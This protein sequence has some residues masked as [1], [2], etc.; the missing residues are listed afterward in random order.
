MSIIQ[1]PEPLLIIHHLSFQVK[2]WFQN[3][4]YKLKKSRSSD[5]QHGYSVNPSLPN[6]IAMRGATDS[7][8]K[9]MMHA[10]AFSYPLQP[11]PP[12]NNQPGNSGECSPTGTTTPGIANSANQP[13][14]A[15][16]DYSLQY[17]NYFPSSYPAPYQT[18]Q[19]TP[20]T[21]SPPTASYHHQQPLPAAVP[22]NLPWY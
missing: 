16:N 6:F 22:S 17:S 20:P 14:I 1:V 18:Q 19:N 15:N 3:H 4:R 5:D 12:T 13:Y 11:V 21:S 8:A 7:Y 10:H 9:S 2:I